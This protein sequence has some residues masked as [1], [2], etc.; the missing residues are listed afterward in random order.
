MIE[1]ILTRIDKTLHKERYLDTYLKNII[2][3]ATGFK[4]SKIKLLTASLSSNKAQTL[5][6]FTFKYNGLEYVLDQGTL[7]L[8]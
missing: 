3:E 8:V 7:K 2:S 4:A 1:R 6:I 5:D